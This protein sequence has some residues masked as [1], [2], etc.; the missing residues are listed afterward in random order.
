MFVFLSVSVGRVL[1]T[2]KRRFTVHIHSRQ[3]KTQF[4]SHGQLTIL[5]MVNHSSRLF[6]VPVPGAQIM[7]VQVRPLS[8][9]QD[10]PRVLRRREGSEVMV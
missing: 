5:S 8:P 2:T 3:L 9:P 4:L 10:P 1:V 6:R 7:P